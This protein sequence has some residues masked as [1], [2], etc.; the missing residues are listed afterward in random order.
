MAKLGTNPLE[1][2]EGSSEILVNHD[3]HGM[4]DTSQ[5]TGNVVVIDGV[6]TGMAGRLTEILEVG[7]NSFVIDGAIEAGFPTDTGVERTFII[8][9]NIDV[10]ADD[11]VIKGTVSVSGDVYTV[12]VTSTIT[13]SHP[14]GAYI[15]YYELG[16][17]KL[18]LV[19]NVPHKVT[20]ATID[21]YVID[22]GSDNWVAD[23]TD[24]IGGSEVVASHNALINDYQ[25]MVPVVTFPGTEV[26]TKVD[27]LNG[28][29]PSGTEVSF[30]NYGETT[31][32]LVERV[33]TRR[34]GMIASGPNEF[35][36]NSGLKSMKVTFEMN[37]TIE[38]LSPIIDLERKSMTTYANR[39]DYI[40]GPEDT[41]ALEYN[42]PT[43]PDGDS[44]EAIYITKRVQL[45]NPATSI[46]V[47][48]DAVRNPSAEIEVMYK[49]LRSD[50]SN[51]FDEIGWSYF[52]GNGGPDIP[53][54]A[55]SDRFSYREYEYTQ[56]NIAEFIAFAIKIK[57]N[58]TSIT[59]VPKIKDLRAIALAL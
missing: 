44:G 18:D 24:S 36:N 58:G 25:L 26:R 13:A 34:A 6:K 51:D 50:D 22:I 5:A 56:D 45:K 12:N 17:L 3:D 31:T 53:V 9:T 14:M 57:M 38:N 55:V 27:F 48:L 46:K 43:D 19:N 35:A 37:S 29:S 49:V 32:E 41:G 59:E 23:T 1:I 21:S 47:I 42:P 30:G 40:K 7:T 4:Y 20:K 11:M 8:R 2:T 16:N 28:T 39:I 10:E 15:E 54:P 52:N 33:A